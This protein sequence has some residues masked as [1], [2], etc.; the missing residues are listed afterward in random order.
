MRK[1]LDYLLVIVGAVLGVAS[2][3]WLLLGLR[4]AVVGGHTIFGQVVAMIFVVGTFRV[5][6]RQARW[7]R[8]RAARNRAAG[9]ERRPGT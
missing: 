7:I 4:F 1:L 8:R 3:V 5:L 6:A 2:V 9:E